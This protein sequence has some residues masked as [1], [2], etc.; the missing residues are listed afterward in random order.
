MCGN[1]VP[2]FNSMRKINNGRRQLP[3]IRLKDKLDHQATSSGAGTTILNDRMGVLSS[4]VNK[5]G[6]KTPKAI[7][8]AICH[9][10]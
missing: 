6:H 1:R 10:D 4:R 3:L 8:A 7:V 2:S 5:T 9:A